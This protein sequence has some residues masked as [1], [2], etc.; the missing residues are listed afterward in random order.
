MLDC[1]RIGRRV[2]GL[3]RDSRK[4]LTAFCALRSLTERTA[5]DSIFFLAMY[6]LDEDWHEISSR[7]RMT[8][9]SV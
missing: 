1:H 5:G 2:I 4:L 9:S 8:R 7:K 6:A 3:D